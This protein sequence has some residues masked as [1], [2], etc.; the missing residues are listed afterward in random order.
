LHDFSNCRIIL[1]MTRITSK[2]DIMPSPPW[3]ISTQ[4]TVP[5]IFPQFVIPPGKGMEAF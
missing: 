4:K 2:N 1:S 3:V 5:I